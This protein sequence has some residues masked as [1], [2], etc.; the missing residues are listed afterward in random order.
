LVYRRKM[1]AGRPVWENGHQVDE[2]AVQPLFPGYF[3]TSFDAAA[4][5]WGDIARAP[6]VR[7]LFSRLRED[8]TWV[9]LALPWGL[10][11]DL[12]ARGRAGD[13]AIDGR[14]PEFPV[15][16]PGQAGR[17]MAGSFESFE[18]TFV[19]AVG[20]DRVKVLLDLFGRKTEVELRRADF[21]A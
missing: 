3:F 8:G 11:E 20:A 6:G 17:V 13:G 16:V 14:C 12:Q 1:R 4:P 15:L 7:R 10:V 18:G 9:P 2:E 19:M 21:A 5:G